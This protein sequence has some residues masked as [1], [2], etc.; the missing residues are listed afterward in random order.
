MKFESQDQWRQLLETAAG[1]RAERRVS[2]NLD[3]GGGVLGT[4]CDLA[5]DGL[6]LPE[7]EKHYTLGQ[8]MPV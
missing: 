2:A 1:Y 3:L 5:V 8:Y 7:R 4:C 6:G